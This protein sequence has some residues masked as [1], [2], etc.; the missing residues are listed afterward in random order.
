MREARDRVTPKVRP[1]HALIMMHL[2]YKP[3]SGSG[4]AERMGENVLTIRPRLV[5]LR[6]GDMIEPTGRRIKNARGIGETEYQLR[7]P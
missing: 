1:I 6:D 7:A 2:N 3:D 4:L 5:E